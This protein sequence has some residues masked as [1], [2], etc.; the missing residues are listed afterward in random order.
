MATVQIT[1]T[2]TGCRRSLPTRD[3]VTVNAGQSTS[4]YLLGNSTVSNGR[5]AEAYVTAY[6]GVSYYKR[7]ELTVSGTVA[8]GSVVYEDGVTRYNITATF[9][10]ASNVTFTITSS[11]TGASVSPIGEQSMASG[12]AQ[13]ITATP[14]EAGGQW[15][16]SPSATTYSSGGKLS[17]YVMEVDAYT[18][19]ATVTINVT[20]NLSRIEI[21]GANEILTVTIENNLQ[22]ATFEP[23]EPIRIAQTQQTDFT[24]TPDPSLFPG[25]WNVTPNMA[26]YSASGDKT[27]VSTFELLDNQA[28][29]LHLTISATT[30]RITIDGVFEHNEVYENYGLIKIYSMSGSLPITLAAKR[31]ASNGAQEEDTGKYILGYYRYPFEVAEKGNENIKL[32]WNDTRVQAPTIEKTVYEFTL[33]NSVVNGLYK[34]VSDIGK[35]EIIIFPPY[36]TPITVDGKFINTKITVKCKIDIVTNRAQYFVYSNDNEI[37]SISASVGFSI[38]YMTG[39]NL[40][41]G[42]VNGEYLNADILTIQ[43]RQSAR[44]DNSASDV[45]EVVTIG[46]VSGYAQFRN[47]KINKSMTGDEQSKLFN[48]LSSGIYVK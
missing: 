39:E 26:T 33:F 28:Y 2:L 23:S 15:T 4:F 29:K 13:V 35:V 44:V 19:V 27:S 17:D 25:A 46:D 3:S 18:N 38:P 11:V 37:E 16:V 22:G 45:L 34:D 32:G 40:Q 5:W 47:V 36:A 41:Y 31:F 14:S 43:V 1:G 8:Q 42:N 6:K 12:A 21:S 7:H 24:V 10:S 48:I 30:R 9:R 20:Q